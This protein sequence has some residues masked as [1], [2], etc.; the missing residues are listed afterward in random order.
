M[1]DDYKIVCVTPAG[2]ERYMRLLVPQIISTPIVD[3][4]QIWVNTNNQT[5]LEFLRMLPVIDNR[6]K[7]IYNDMPID[8]NL[9]IYRFFRQA[10]EPKTVYIRFDDDIVWMEQDTI[11]KIARF[12]ISNP[13]YFLTSPIII[14]N[15]IITSLLIMLGKITDIHH[16][17]PDVLSDLAWKNPEFAYHF[18]KRFLH[19]I[20]HNQL[21]SLRFDN[22]QIF[23]NRWSIN[24]ISWLGDMFKSFDGVIDIDEE[25]YLTTIKPTQMGI[26][27]CIHGDTIVS[28]FSF[29]TQRDYLDSTE[30]LSE[31]KKIF[32][33]M[34]W[35]NKQ[36]NVL[37]IRSWWNND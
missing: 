14:N 27:N 35:I 29:F 34:T 11:E 12:R 25:E 5:D 30:I 20:K 32:D 7:C 9:S 18:H 15:A 21:D 36:I 6:I 17:R 26:G 31:Y 22:R 16:I 13:Q 3:E 37:P 8:G 2:R 10:I 33:N 19:L 24:C 28:H 1:L 23:L 4:Y